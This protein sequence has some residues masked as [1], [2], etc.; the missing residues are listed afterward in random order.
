[1]PKIKVKPS[2]IQARILRILAEPG[3]TMSVLFGRVWINNNRAYKKENCIPSTAKKLIRENWITPVEPG[4]SLHA[5]TAAGMDAIAFLAPDDFVTVSLNLM[6]ST[7]V[8]RCLR[9]HVF[10][11][12]YWMLVDELWISTDELT[13]NRRIDAFAMKMSTPSD[14]KIVTSDVRGI[15]GRRY[16][17][18]WALEI[19]VSREDFLAELA[20]PSKRDPA[21]AISNRFAFVAPVG[22]IKPEEL[23][24]GAGLI[25][26]ISSSEAQL[27]VRSDHNRPDEPTWKLVAAIGRRMAGD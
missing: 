23:P 4:K 3:V 26:I 12:P 11:S 20:E 9:K 16:L 25:E 18:T 24:E 17:E 2:A 6:K 21:I 27:T 5:I 1:M 22:L 8:L 14:P 10:P 13:H 15:A 19:K 7:D